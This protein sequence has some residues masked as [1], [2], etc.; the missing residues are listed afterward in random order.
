MPQATFLLMVP[1]DLR[2]IR[3]LRVERP[4]CTLEGIPRARNEHAAGQVEAQVFIELVA[5]VAVN[6]PAQVLGLALE[7][8]LGGPE[9]EG[10]EADLQFVGRGKAGGYLYVAGV[11]KAET[12]VTVAEP[13]SRR[14]SRA[15]PGRSCRYTGTRSCR[16]CCCTGCSTRGP[17]AWWRKRCCRGRRRRPGCRISADCWAELPEPYATSAPTLATFMS[18]ISA[19]S[20]AA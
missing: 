3:G 19:P 7:H 20:I 12:A 9:V 4:C 18:F 11:G 8:G 14:R 17:A 2:M 10:V 13:V 15:G 5:D 1:S 16:T 6:F